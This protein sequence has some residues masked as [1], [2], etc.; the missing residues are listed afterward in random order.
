MPWIFLSYIVA[1]D[2]DGDGS[3]D[4]IPITETQ[5]VDV[6]ALLDIASF[7]QNLG[8]IVDYFPYKCDLNRFFEL[9]RK[10]SIV[11][12]ALNSPSM[13]QVFTDDNIM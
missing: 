11:P 8:D 1:K 10:S 7:I 12:V 6:C 4:S 13:M 3:V 5:R 9:M 2:K